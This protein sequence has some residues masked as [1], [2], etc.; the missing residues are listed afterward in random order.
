MGGPTLMPGWRRQGLYPVYW[1]EGAGSLQVKTAAL[2]FPCRRVAD[3][4]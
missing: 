2:D 3:R 4:P 1:T